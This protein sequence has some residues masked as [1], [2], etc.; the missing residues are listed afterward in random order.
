MVDGIVTDDNLTVDGFD[1]ENIFAP[2][3]VS[4]RLNNIKVRDVVY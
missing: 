2:I 3:T 4:P 1:I